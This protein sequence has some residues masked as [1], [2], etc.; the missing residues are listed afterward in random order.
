MTV[1]VVLF[2]GFNP[3]LTLFQGK[4]DK[5]C[6]VTSPRI[7]APD[8]S[9]LPFAREQI[10]HFHADFGDAAETGTQLAIAKVF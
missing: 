6:G 10:L 1:C 3:C 2:I 7:S 8:D 5:K 4:P 9:V